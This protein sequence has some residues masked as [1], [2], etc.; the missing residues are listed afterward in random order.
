[1]FGLWIAL[2]S[3]IEP[4]RRV[5]RESWRGDAH[6]PPRC[7]STFEALPIGMS[8]ENQKKLAPALGPVVMSAIGRK[9]QAMYADINARGVPERLSPSC[10]GWANRAMRARHP[11]VGSRRRTAADV[12]IHREF[13]RTS[14]RNAVT[15]KAAGNEPRAVAATCQSIKSADT[16]SIT[17]IS[18]PSALAVLRLMANSNLVDC[19]TGRSAGLVPL[20]M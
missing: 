11:P 6:T 10:A 13:R 15:K 3:S 4:V 8:N 16:L 1:L 9:L 19:W 20:R 5:V 14:R 12:R 17:G 18:S 7:A 2:S